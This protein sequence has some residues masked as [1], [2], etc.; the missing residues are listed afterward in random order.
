MLELF[1]FFFV[2]FLAVL[3]FDQFVE[4]WRFLGL[5]GSEN[6]M[7]KSFNEADGDETGVINR[8]E[9]VDAILNNRK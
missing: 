8:E 3:E 1:F 6:V 5:G 4:T 9:F 7:K 2:L